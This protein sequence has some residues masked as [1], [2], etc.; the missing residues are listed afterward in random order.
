MGWFHVYVGGRKKKNRANPQKMVSLHAISLF[1]AIRERKGWSRERVKRN[2]EWVSKYTQKL[3]QNLSTDGKVWFLWESWEMLRWISEDDFLGFP[4]SK[5]NGTMVWAT[6]D[7]VNVQ[8]VAERWE[9]KKIGM[10]RK[11]LFHHTNFSFYILS[12]WYQ[13]QIK[14]YWSSIFEFYIVSCCRRRKRCPFFE[15]TPSASNKSC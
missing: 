14:T 15:T 9:G 13:K 11:R 10:N 6:I 1:L 2:I 4:K 7:M 12:L 3:M 8:K 5:F